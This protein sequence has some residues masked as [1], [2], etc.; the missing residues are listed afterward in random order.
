MKIKFIAHGKLIVYKAVCCLI[1]STLYK[2]NGWNEIVYDSYTAGTVYLLD[3]C[4]YKDEIHV[5]Q[6]KIIL[7]ITKSKETDACVYN[8]QAN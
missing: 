2:L 1:C 6:K 4:I 5:T 8:L 7:N 3:K